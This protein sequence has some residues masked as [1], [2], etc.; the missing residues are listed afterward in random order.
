MP[1]CQGFGSP[2]SINGRT[3]SADFGLTFL[4]NGHKKPSKPKK[5]CRNPIALAQEWQ[6]LLESGAA[7]SR[8]DL[9]R[10]LGFSRAHVTQILRLIDLAPQVKGRV[11]SLGDP[12]EGL[13]LGA[14]TLRSLAKL[15][16]EEQESRIAGMLGKNGH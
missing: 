9:A 10:Q 16:V 4:T 6:R 5:L 11:L 12:T 15:P 1:F 7:T 3:F 8:A 14:H 2:S 13:I